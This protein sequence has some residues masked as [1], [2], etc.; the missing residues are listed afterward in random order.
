[1][2]TRYEVLNLALGGYATYNILP[3][4]TPIPTG[5]NRTIDTQR[6]I[7]KALELMPGG[8]IINMP[9]NDAAS[10]YP[11]EDQLNNYNL[12]STD[13]TDQNVPLW[14]TTPQPRNFG[15]NT[16]NQNIQIQMVTETNNLF[17]EFAVDFWTD[18]GLENN[19]GILPQYDA[20]DGIHMNDAGHQILYDRII[21]KGIHTIVKNNADALDIEEF[22]SNDFMLFPNPIS[23]TATIKFSETITGNVTISVMDMLG[24]QIA[25]TSETP[26]S[27]NAMTWS[28]NNLKSGFYIMH[29]S[30]QNK[31]LTKRI[32]IN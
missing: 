1:M 9:S 27:H 14:V 21:G 28:R 17:G 29:I 30:Y 11:V 13:A 4:G 16:T 10:G 6:N 20:G 3:T 8:I 24:K 26:T 15:S 23:T 7:T 2:D 25:K 22:V 19:N 32:L 31:V 12:I 5:V 18:L